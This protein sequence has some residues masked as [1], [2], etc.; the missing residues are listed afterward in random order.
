MFYNARWYDSQLGRFAQADS[1]V[2]GG[3]QGY[4][5]FAYVNNNPLR[6]TDPTGHW[7]ETA[8]DV[9]FIVYDIY[10]ISSNGLNWTNG[11]SLAAD[12]VCA[13]LPVAT[14]GG[15][16]VRAGAH[17]DDAV[18]VVNKADDVVDAEK[19]LADVAEIYA[20]AVKNADSPL[21][22]LGTAR[23]NYVEI[24]GDWTATHLQ[25]DLY[26]NFIKNYGKE[27][28]WK[29]VNLPFI[30]RE[31]IGKNK[32]IILT[33]SVDVIENILPK[34]TNTYREFQE[35]MKAGYSKIGQGL[36]APR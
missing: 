35:L 31:V 14:G 6:Y 20:D 34:T 22:V 23:D 24:A 3:V 19:Y 25:T 1:I 4:D 10:D 13:V 18:K 2:P 9:A 32:N 26:D 8:L 29:D 30:Q 12:G 15:L 33:T 28:F 7:F 16:L 27:A 36:L 11:L 5:R 17:V 21:G